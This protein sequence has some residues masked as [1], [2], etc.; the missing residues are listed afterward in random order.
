MVVGRHPVMDAI[1][2]GKSISKILLQQGTT[3]EFEKDLRRLCKL[4]N[5]PMQIVPKERI[6]KMHGGNH[7]GVIAITSPVQYYQLEDILPAIY[8][9]GEIPL[10]VILD[11]ITD[12]RNFGAIA[13]SAEVCGA[14][15]IVIGRKNSAM[16]TPDAVKTSAGALNTIPVCRES[17]IGNAIDFLKNSG[18]KIFASSL[19]GKK[20]LQ[21][22]DIN[23]PCAFVLGSED[24]GIS[25]TVV[26]AADELFI[27][28]QK[29]VTDSLNVSVA[30][31]IM[32]YEAVRQR[33]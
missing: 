5:I 19:R 6:N 32:M 1:H 10:L 18:V 30:A 4:S 2:A 3:G 8:E 12:V 24:K 11:G 22:L 9:K 7:Q 26:K 20:P 28:P 25:S 23:D 13:R 16:I 33:G 29:G 27:I 15:A 14:H 21:Q 17:G 31:G